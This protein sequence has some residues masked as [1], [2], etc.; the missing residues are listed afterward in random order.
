MVGSNSTHLG[1]CSLPRSSFITTHLRLPFAVNILKVIFLSYTTESQLLGL[2]LSFYIF[3][4]ICGINLC[5]VLYCITLFFFFSSFFSVYRINFIF[6]HSVFLLR[7]SNSSKVFNNFLISYQNNSGYFL[8]SQLVAVTF[9][10][11]KYATLSPVNP[12]RYHFL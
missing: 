5:K 6:L 8:L 10:K 7:Q 11:T 1:L 9:N 4:I 2:L 12:Y 3:S